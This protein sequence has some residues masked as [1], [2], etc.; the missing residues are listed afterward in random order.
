MKKTAV[1]IFLLLSFW[2]IPSRGQEG[3]PE[4]ALRHMTKGEAAVETAKSPEDYKNAIAEFTQACSLAPDWPDPRYNLGVVQEAAGEYEDAIKSFQI[5]L[6]LSPEA[7]DAAD[8]KKRIY[9]LEYARDR[10]NIEG[11]WKVDKSR[12][13][14]K[15]NP[16]D[17]VLSYGSIVGSSMIIEDLQLNVRKN[18]D[19]TEVRLLTVDDYMGFNFR[20]GP[21]SSVEHKG[22]S[23]TIYGAVLYACPSDVMANNCPWDVKLILKQ[24]SSDVMEGT[25]EANGGI[26][27]IPDLKTGKVSW[28]AFTGAGTILFRRDNSGK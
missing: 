4:E 15:C 20:E 25:I 5:Y 6:T 28:R 19:K 10:N 12:L 26:K 2:T 3:I 21:F 17:C 14:V 23:V 22:D 7:D 24:T 9:K 1:M 18:Q 27:T 16:T 11:T 8:V 13:S